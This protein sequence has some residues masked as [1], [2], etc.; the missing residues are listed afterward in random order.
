M[1]ATFALDYKYPNRYNE[2]NSNGRMGLQNSEDPKNS[3]FLLTTFTITLY[4]FW[5]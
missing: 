5:F 4:E 2:H 3:E 1:A